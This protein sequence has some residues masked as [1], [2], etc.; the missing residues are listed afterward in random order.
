MSL[1]L[2]QEEKMKKYLGIA[3]AALLVFGL[4]GQA[5][6]DFTPWTNG[7]MIRVVYQVSAGAVSI[8]AATD[9]GTESAVQ[10]GSLQSNS[11]NLFTGGT[12]SQFSGLS[13][14]AGSNLYVAYFAENDALNGGNGSVWVSGSGAAGATANTNKQSGLAGILSSLYGEYS[15]YS[16]TNTAWALDSD[17]STYYDTVDGNGTNKSNFASLL[18]TANGEATLASGTA[19]QGIYYVA[20]PGAAHTGV[21]QAFLLNTQL[22]AVYSGTTLE[23]YTLTTTE[24][25][26]PPTTPIPASVLL[27]GSGLLGLIGIRRKNVFNF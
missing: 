6:A 18:K 17:A 10:G 8:E 3:A 11:V 12:N 5:K 27:F 23:D 25:A 20:T 24:Q 19:T 13:S 9:L 26:I 2:S 14:S 22:T 4:A 1:F 15:N 16:A 21:A 7:D